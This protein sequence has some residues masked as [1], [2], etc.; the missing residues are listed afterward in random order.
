[1]LSAERLKSPVMTDDANRF[2][3]LRLEVWPEG[4]KLHG[5]V[6]RMWRKFSREETFGLA[7]RM[8]R[9]ARS[10]CA[11][12]AE[13]SGRNSDRDFAQFFEIAHASAAEVASR[14]SGLYR[15]LTGLAGR[16]AP[17]SALRAP[18]SPAA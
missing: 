6:S 7:S 11:S 3:F 5:I 15:K 13:G 16:G 14:S 10:A 8:R 9:S 17:R 18:R 2:R 1:M 4:R 12:I